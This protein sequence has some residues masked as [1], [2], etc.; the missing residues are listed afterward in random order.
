MLNVLRKNKGFSLVELMIV[1][2][3]IGILAAVA[4][5]N[6][7]RFQRKARQSEARSLLSGL[8]T[9]TSAAR[10]EWGAYVGNFM[11]NGF[12]PDGQLTYRVDFAQSANEGTLN[13]GQPIPGAG[14]AT[15][16]TTFGAHGCAAAFAMWVQRPNGVA[17]LQPGPSAAAT[18]GV[19]NTGAA[20]VATVGAFIGGAN[21][22]H[23]A[24]NETKTVQN[25]SLGPIAGP[26]TIGLD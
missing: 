24:I 20:F 3:I 15:C 2:A 26:T 21:V 18:A 1:V 22:D 5:P 4:I 25:G 14:P 10:S 8:Y 6:F 9:A 11:A 19:T 17:S 12:A 7:Q 13:S 23:W 16:V